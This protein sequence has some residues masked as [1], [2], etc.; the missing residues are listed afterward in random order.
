MTTG[1]ALMGSMHASDLRGGAYVDTLADLR[2]RA[3]QGVGVDHRAFI[4]IGA[5]VDDTLEACR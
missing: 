2:T 5:D 3:D 1:A 4:D